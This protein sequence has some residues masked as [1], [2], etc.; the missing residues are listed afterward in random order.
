[1]SDAVPATPAAAKTA[2][3]ERLRGRL[4][5]LDPAT[6]AAAADRVG[7]SVLA[8]PEITR[9]RRILACLSFG[10]E[11]DTWRLVDRLRAAGK[12][13]CVP[14]AD[15]RDGRL[16]VHPYPCAL[17]TLA[18]GLRQPPRGTPEVA[19]EAIDA[20]VDAVLVLGLGF[21][22]R[23]YRLGYGS[24]YFDRFLAGRPFPAVGLAFAMQLEDELPS[25]P[26]D[27]PL[28]VIVT[29]AGICRPQ[30]LS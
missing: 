7:E 17:R 28:T 29:E 22:R 14:R 15:P 21:D 24:G 23:G 26:H 6:T 13:L 25:E 12:D 1:M 2:W 10:A 16:H 3:R 19:T 30:G 11:I 9:A 18:F 27:I 20:T 8:L 5:A 4:A